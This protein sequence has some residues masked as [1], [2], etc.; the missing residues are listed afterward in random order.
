VRA[1]SRLT[2]GV[3]PNIVEFGYYGENQYWLFTNK[4]GTPALAN[5]KSGNALRLQHNAQAN[6]QLY[7]SYGP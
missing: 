6:S 4:F 7:R 5:Y 1:E 2:K 3:F